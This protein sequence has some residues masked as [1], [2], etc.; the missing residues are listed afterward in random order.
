MIRNS[1]QRQSTLREIARLKE[2]LVDLRHREVRKE[3]RDLQESSIRKMLRD[4][5]HQLEVYREAERGR[6]APT[7]L[8]RLLSPSKAGGRPRIGEAM[9]LLRVARKMTQADLARKLGTR[10]EVIARWE[11][12]DY[13]GYTLESLQRI[14]EALG[15]RLALLVRV[16]G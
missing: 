5:E 13:D 3:L 10:R 6:V 15:C 11:R 14:F 12:E 8:E 7:V 4:L 2:R 16:A 1:A 9:V